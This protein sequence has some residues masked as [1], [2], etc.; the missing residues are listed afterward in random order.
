[1]LAQVGKPHGILAAMA[2]PTHAKLQ[3]VVQYIVR[4]FREL[5]VQYIGLKFCREM[6]EGAFVAPN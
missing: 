2:D 5:C 3:L 6:D 1:V 4:R